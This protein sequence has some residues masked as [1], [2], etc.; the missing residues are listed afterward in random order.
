MKHI[1]KSDGGRSVLASI[2]SIAIGLLVGSL[3]VLAVGLCSKDMGLSGAIEGIKLILFGLFSTGRNAM[4]ALTFGFNPASI[5][6]MLFR[7]TPLIL[8]EIGRAHV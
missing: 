1:L 8:T 7:A 4:G 6:N 5:G 3:L 2:I